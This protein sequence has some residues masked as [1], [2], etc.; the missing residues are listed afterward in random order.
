MSSPEGSTV[1]FRRIS[2]GVRP[3]ALVTFARKLE[4][5]VSKGRPFD[6]LI[7]GNAELRRLNREFRGKDEPTDVLSF[8]SGQQ[9]AARGGAPRTL[10]DLAISL[11][12][13]RAQAV[14]FGHTTE[15]EV[16][17]LMLHG[18]LHLMGMDHESDDGRMARAEK[19]WRTRLGLP[20][21]LIERV[22]P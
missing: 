22:R 17:V 8:P 1:T 12:R 18:L 7:A 20:N 9:P 19:R 15:Q 5:E 14:D 2:G 11:P 13:A 3:R 21:G 10:G 4:R 16:R 6:C